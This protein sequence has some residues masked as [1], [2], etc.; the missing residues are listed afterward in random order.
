LHFVTDCCGPCNHFKNAYAHHFI[1]D[2]DYVTNPLSVN[3]EPIFYV[4]STCTV[5]KNNYL[6]RHVFLYGRNDLAF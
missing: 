1:F 5:K 2:P 6:A 4:Y 3:D